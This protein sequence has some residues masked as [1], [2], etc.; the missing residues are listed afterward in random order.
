M[1][2]VVQTSTRLVGGPVTCSGGSTV[3][4]LV[5]VWPVIAHVI[6]SAIKLYEQKL[7]RVLLLP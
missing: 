1:V 4:V 5:R 6:V 7:I 2:K 3:M